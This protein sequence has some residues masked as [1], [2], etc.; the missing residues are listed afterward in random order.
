MTPD[1]FTP[2][3][4]YGKGI[5]IEV[6]EWANEPSRGSLDFFLRNAW[7]IGCLISK[8]IFYIITSGILELILYAITF[9][10]IRANTNKIASTGILRS[11]VIKRRR[12]QNSINIYMTF[13]AWLV[14]FF[15][16]MFVLV[17]LKVAFGRSP[18]FHSMVALMHLT[19]NFNILPFFYIVLA[20]EKIKQA[21]AKRYSN[22]ST[23]ESVPSL[24]AEVE[25]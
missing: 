23:D 10:R 7:S 15:T 5:C 19:L 2:G 22:S 16:S 4:R 12:Q 24:T 18:F 3:R 11:K 6:A 14:Q 21:I 17:L 9:R 8:N 25:N 20:D 1:T 13:W